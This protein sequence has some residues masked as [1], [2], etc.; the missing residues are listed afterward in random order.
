MMTILTLLLLAGVG[1][2]LYRWYDRNGPPRVIEP[3]L[4]RLARLAPAGGSDELGSLIAAL[5]ASLVDRSRRTWWTRRHYVEGS[6]CVIA[7]SAQDADFLLESIGAVEADLNVALRAN[8]TRHRIVIGSPLELVGVVVDETI[9]PGHPRL[10]PA[11]AASSTVAAHVPRS[12][13]AAAEQRPKAVPAASR[14]TSSSRTNFGSRWEAPTTSAKTIGEAFVASDVCAQLL[15]IDQDPPADAPIGVPFDGVVLGRSSEL[16]AG[17]V[18]LPTVSARHAELRRQAGGWV[19]RDLESRNGTFV[20]GSRINETPLQ[21]G[22][23]IGLGHRV[24]LRFVIGDGAQRP[25]PEMDGR[26]T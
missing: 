17:K 15:P 10:A 25:A 26:S 20:E 8:A 24:K 14:V 7:A 19:L 18:A 4:A 11:G 3:L 2:A 21:S 6:R 1:W 23:V 12:A 13:P 5:Y 22:D 9:A 16:G